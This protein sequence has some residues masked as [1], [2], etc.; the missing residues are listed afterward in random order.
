VLDVDT[1]TVL[2]A[3]RQFRDEGGLLDSA[4]DGGHRRGNAGPK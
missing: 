3:L 4:A 1:N 2:R